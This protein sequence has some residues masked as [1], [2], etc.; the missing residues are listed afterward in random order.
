VLR[1][2]RGFY[3][4]REPF[5]DRLLSIRRN[6]PVVVVAIDT[7]AGVRR[8]WPAVDELTREAG[9]VTAELVPASH[10]LGSEGPGSLSLAST[11]TM[12]LG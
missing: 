12:E 11:P 2:V 1:G 10:G 9:L 4:D 5:A 8:W 6:V 3:G 7:P